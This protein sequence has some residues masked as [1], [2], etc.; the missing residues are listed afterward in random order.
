MNGTSRHSSNHFQ[1]IKLIKQLGKRLL[2]LLNYN[3]QDVSDVFM[4]TFEISYEIFGNVHSI[5]LKSDP[6][7]IVTKQNKQ[8]FVT[9]YT[10]HYA[11]Y[12]YKNNLIR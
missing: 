7:E 1:Y 8:E 12:Q 9:L 11:D 5:P 4:R 6:Q 2:Q 10:T 3:D